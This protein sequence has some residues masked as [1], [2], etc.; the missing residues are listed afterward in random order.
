MKVFMEAGLPDGVINMVPGSGSVISE[1]VL[2]H[3]D[4]AG[5]HFTGSNNTFDFLWT[6][7][8]KN[9]KKYKSYP[10]LVGETGGK[11]FIFAHPSA[12]PLE[13]STALFAGAFE[14]QGQKCS[15][16][17]RAYIPK[18]MWGKVKENLIAFRSKVTMGDSKD[19][20]NFITAVIDEKSFD[21]IMSYIKYVK[22][23]NDAEII[24]GGEGDKSKGYFVEPTV[25][26]TTN[27]KFK[28]IQEEIFG[29]VLT[30]YV[31]EDDKFKETLE[32]CDETSPY[33]LT[34]SIFS[35]ERYGLV[36]AY[37]TLRYSAGNFYYNDK[38]T[39]AMVGK[40]P[41]GGS[42][43]SG[44]NDKAGSMYN[45]LRWV[46]PRTIKE[47]LVPPTDILYSYMKK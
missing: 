29:P 32:L 11:D 27:P 46:S 7:T 12:D 36:E 13:V 4:L 39:G 30:V 40:Q 9:L 25:V 43:R 41:F 20:N 37:N 19:L 38:C 34:G 45:L 8:A 14:F 28:T 10:K 47:T 2:N 24:F 42:R 15:A 26:L 23:A 22:E 18:S 33:G 16:C 31:Y 21:N 17:S 35:K 44:T 5:I 1:V 3:K 6:E